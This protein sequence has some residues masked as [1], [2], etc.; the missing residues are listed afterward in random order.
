MFLFSRMSKYISNSKKLQI[1]SGAFISFGMALFST[2]SA[3]ASDWSFYSE[4]DTITFSESF[5]IFD[6]LEEVEGGGFAE[7]G[8]NGFTHNQFEIG[9]RKGPWDFALLTRYDYLAEY[10]SDGA[11]LLL[12]NEL[13]LSVPSDDYEIFVQLNHSKSH[14]VRLGYHYKLT[15]D[16]TLTGRVSGLWAFGIVEGQLEGDLTFSDAELETGDL[17][18]DYVFTSDIVF[19]RDFER[20]TGLGASFDV[21][22][23][24]K[25]S[26]N[27]SVEAAAYD[28][29]SRIWWDELP[30]TVADATTSISRLQDNGIL[31]VRPTINGQNFFE[32]FTQRL[33]PRYKAEFDYQLSSSWSVS[34]DIFSLGRNQLT[35]TEVNYHLGSGQKVGA[36]YE[37]VSNAVGINFYWNDLKLEFATDSFNPKNAR[38]A[39]LNVNFTKKF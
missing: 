17:L 36:S 22:A 4:F 34:Q 16:F 32:D 12:A 33:E 15:P 10:T 37:W 9:A 39:K 30:R 5:S 3:A 21:I 19:G 14:G 1:L 20:Q 35:E 8:N 25:L 29:F 23:Q 18:L 27:I 24:W 7:N 26:E 11:T 28:V 2:T 31:I 13:G 38:Y 6:V